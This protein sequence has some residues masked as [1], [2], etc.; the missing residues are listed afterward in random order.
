VVDLKTAAGFSVLAGS[1]ITNAG[2]TTVWGDIGIHPGDA[3]DDQGSLVVAGARHLADEVARQAQED[4]TTAYGVA[5]GQLPRIDA[6]DELGGE[7]LVGGVY[8]RAAAMALNGQLILDGANNPDSVWV[9]QAGTTLVT[10]SS[11]SIVLINGADPC[12]VFWQVGSSA[13]LGT[14]TAFVGSIMADQSIALKTGATLEGRALARIAAV[15][16][17]SNVITQPLCATETPVDETPVDETP[18]DETPV[19]ETPVDETPMDETPM[20]ETPVDETPVDETPVDETPVDETRT[21]LTTGLTDSPPAPTV[22]D[23][24]PHTGL[25]G[26]ASSAAATPSLPLTLGGL[27]AVGAFVALVGAS[28]ATTRH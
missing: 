6:D 12:N 8:N 23:G 10:G 18:V 4:L 13:T 16:L 22:P 25:G 19:D 17:E 15:T 1:T 7:T 27:L 3:I 9:F 26:A 21:G 5:A 28:R 14:G 2:T 11:S 20:D 24:H